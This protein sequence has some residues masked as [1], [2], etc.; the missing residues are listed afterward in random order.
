MKKILK[1]VV[2]L[3]FLATFAGCVK[4]NGPNGNTDLA[5]YTYSVQPN[6]WYERGDVGYS[7]FQVF[8][9]IDIP[10][11][12]Q[13]VM[14]YGAVMVYVKRDDLN[15]FY[16]LPVITNLY[17]NVNGYAYVNTIQNNVYLGMVEIFI[18]DTDY[19]TVVPGPMTFKVVVFNQLKSLPASLNIKDYKQVEAYLNN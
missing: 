16:P 15:L 5:N 13:D 11:I 9:E 17:D 14:D 12:T 6:Q 10:G 8:C 1:S 7:G 3:A 19:L 4:D 18:E 2:F